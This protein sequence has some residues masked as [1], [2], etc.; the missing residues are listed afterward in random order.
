MIA[1]KHAFQVALNELHIMPLNP[2]P[3]KRGSCR[4]E[5]SYSDGLPYPSR[6]SLPHHA[7]KR[8]DLFP[9]QWRS[10]RPVYRDKL[11]P[12]IML[13]NQRKNPGLSRLGEARQIPRRYALIKE[14]MPFPSVTGRVCYHPCEQACIVESTMKPFRFAQSR[15]FSAILAST[16]QRRS[17]ARKSNGKKI[18]VVG[19][20]PPATARVQLARLG[21]TVTI[22]EN[23]RKLADSIAA[24]FRIGSPTNILDREIERLEQLGV[25][26][27]TA[28]SWQRVTWDDLKK[29]Y[30][31]CVLAVGLTDQQRARR[32]E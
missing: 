31:A 3:C 11:P 7:G 17:E 2:V 19:S 14:D 8:Q 1:N 27:K 15:D 21:Y 28:S 26:I 16:H 22:L 30:D 20:V 25:T 24:A 9:T 23:L 4:P 5:H 29:D 10:I 13:R 12:C 18:A 6:A 32:S